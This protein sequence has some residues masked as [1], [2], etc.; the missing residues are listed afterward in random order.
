MLKKIELVGVKLPRLYIAENTD[1]IRIAKSKGI[2][3]VK[4][5][6]G[7]EQLLRQMLRP[8]LEKMFPHIKW[9][10]VLGEKREFKSAIVNVPG[11]E[12]KNDNVDPKDLM[13][14]DKIIE[15]QH[16]HVHTSG[17]N[18][19]FEVAD[20]AESERTFS[21]TSTDEQMFYDKCDI[22]QYVGDL[23]SSVNIDVLQNLKLLPKFMGDIVDCIKINLS[24]NM[25]WTEGYNKKR[26]VPIGTFD[27]STMLPNL[28][29]LDV[30]GSIPRGISA[31][32]LTLIDT[33]RSDLYADLII[34]S[35][36]SVYYPY[37][38]ELPTPQQLRDYF[39]FNNEATM[40]YR[41][42]R[43]HVAGRHWGHVIS[44]GDYDAPKAYEEYEENES[45]R[46]PL[47]AGTTVKAVH[48]YHTC[49]DKHR[50]GYAQWVHDINPNVE[51]HYDCSWCSIINRR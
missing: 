26:G 22:E 12:V 1:D 15:M 10:K 50:T 42:L 16:K 38:S 7:M 29:I 28:I 27:R 41:I 20:I 4:W 32:M 35:N 21:G 34:T 48:H 19:G 33:M 44:F 9:D 49:D 2:P 6:L 46:M 37:G 14:N 3:Y 31:T 18:A 24:N 25:Q 45:N 8:T 39:G 5:N 40:F 30:S 23:S 13:D 43:N 36:K 11:Q 17:N 51:E 47:M